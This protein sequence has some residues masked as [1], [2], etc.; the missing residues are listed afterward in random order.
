MIQEEDALLL[1]LTLEILINT[2][3]KQSISSL[4]KDLTLDSTSLLEEKQ[5]YQSEMFSLFVKSLKEQLFAIFS[6]KLVI[7]AVIRDVQEHMPLL[8]V[9]LKMDQ[10]P[11]LD[12]PLELEKQLT[13]VAE[14]LSV[15]LQVGEEMK[16]PS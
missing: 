4:L 9:I 2:K 1:K 13:E 14:L 12:F 11:E 6:Q 5:P 16:N 7:K 8:S 10:R 3:S 15:L